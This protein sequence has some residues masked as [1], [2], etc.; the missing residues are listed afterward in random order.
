[1]K[2]FITSVFLSILLIPLLTAEDSHAVK[3]SF[4]LQIGTPGSGKGQLQNPTGI[5]AGQ[6]GTI[7]IVDSKN[8]RI[9]LFSLAGEFKSSF[10]AKGE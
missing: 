9:Q 6:D 8:N 2:K 1:M 7:Y 10:G 3:V 4:S 5:A